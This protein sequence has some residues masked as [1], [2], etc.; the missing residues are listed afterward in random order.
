MS[1]GS[2]LQACVTR[3]MK[4]NQLDGAYRSFVMLYFERSDD[5]WRK[6]CHSDCEPCMLGRTVDRIRE[7]LVERAD[8]SGVGIVST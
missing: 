5:A 3:A 4:D 6:C 8:Q 2:I 7:L 1:D